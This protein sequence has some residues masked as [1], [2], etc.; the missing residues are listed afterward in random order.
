M[1]FLKYGLAEIASILNRTEVYLTTN[2]RVDTIPSK[3]SFK[4]RFA[5]HLDPTSTFSTSPNTKKYFDLMFGYGTWYLNSSGQYVLETKYYNLTFC[6]ESHFPMWTQQQFINSGLNSSYCPEDPNLQIDLRGTYDLANQ[7]NYMEVTFRQCVSQS[8]HEICANDSEVADFLK[9]NSD[10]IYLDFFIINNILD[11]GNYEKPFTPFVDKIT[12][13]IGFSTYK[14][15]EIY[16]TPVTL[17]TD[18]NRG[19]AYFRDQINMIQTNDFMYERKFDMF[20]DNAPRMDNNRKVYLNMNI[21]ST[22]LSKVYQRSY[23]TL[24]DYCQTIGSLYSLFSLIFGILNKLIVADKLSLKIAKS[25]Y[26]L[27]KLMNFGRIVQPEK[28]HRY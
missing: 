28:T 6:N 25:L 2:D 15:L 16:L 3:I 14:Q 21:Q 27:K 5:I 9:S 24:G 12:N 7:Y 13:V 8:E 26:N 1:K 20:Y 19:F 4:N 18:P 10:G 23:D 11:S 22:I 17:Q